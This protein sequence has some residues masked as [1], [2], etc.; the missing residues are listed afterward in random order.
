MAKK[1]NVNKHVF[2]NINT[3]S[4]NVSIF[5]KN[6]EVKTKIVKA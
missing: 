6:V 2:I 4:F 3:K 1:I 5:I